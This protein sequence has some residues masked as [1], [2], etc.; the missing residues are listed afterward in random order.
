MSIC[1]VCMIASSRCHGLVS[2]EQELTR[3]S[4]KTQRRAPSRCLSRKRILSLARLRCATTLFLDYHRRSG[5]FLGQHYQDF[6]RFADRIQVFLLDLGLQFSEHY[7][8]ERHCRGN[9][10]A[11]YLS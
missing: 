7:S 2:T 10:S 3:T 1:L 11:V 8:G 5:R 9:R 4:P 6:V